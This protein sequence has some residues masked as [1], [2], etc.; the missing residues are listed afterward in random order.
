MVRG[1][2][3]KNLEFLGRDLARTA[4]LDNSIQAFAYHLENGI[5]CQTWIDDDQDTELLDL[6]PFLKSLSTVQD[7]RPII[8]E[9]FQLRE[10]IDKI[11][12]E[13]IVDGRNAA[14]NSNPNTGDSV[15][16]TPPTTTTHKEPP[17]APAN[18]PDHGY[19]NGDSLH[20]HPS[21]PQ[22]SSS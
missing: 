19:G 9:K 4:I 20:A 22:P 3:V 13:E 17:P 7:V 8:R 21:N 12:Q 15:P 16:G 14:A 6:L 5:P 2:Y 18:S 1:T 11:Y 10:M